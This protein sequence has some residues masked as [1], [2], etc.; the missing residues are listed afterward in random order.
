MK[1]EHNFIQYSAFQ[2]R[3]VTNII[4]GAQ[5]NGRFLDAP[6]EILISLGLML[7]PGIYIFNKLPGDSSD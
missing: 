3:S 1:K 6:L 5:L 7:A 2:S 4:W